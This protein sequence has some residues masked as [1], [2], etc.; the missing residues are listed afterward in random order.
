[1]AILNILLVSMFFITRVKCNIE[2]TRY[3]TKP[4]HETS[5]GLR[6]YQ[7]HDGRKTSKIRCGGECT[8][9]DECQSFY[10]DEGACVLGVIDL[11][12]FERNNEVFPSDDTLLK[13]KGNILFSVI[14]Y[15]STCTYTC[16]CKHFSEYCKYGFTLDGASTVLLRAMVKYNLFWQQNAFS[17]TK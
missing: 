8:K 11:Q 17:Q 3:S 15:S 12:Q 14:L 16:T 1:M 6:F 2:E 4:L 5:G 9:F 7:M 10:L 13:T